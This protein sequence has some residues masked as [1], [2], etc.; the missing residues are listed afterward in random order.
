MSVS[1]YYPLIRKLSLKH[2]TPRVRDVTVELTRDGRF[3]TTWTALPSEMRQ[4]KTFETVDGANSFATK[5]R[6]RE[7]RSDET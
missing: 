6:L 5:L 2:E 1:T 3:R 4:T 7:E